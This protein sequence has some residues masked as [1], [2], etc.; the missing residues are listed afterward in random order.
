MIFCNTQ[1]AWR[2][3]SPT[4]P[5]ISSSPSQSGVAARRTPL[6]RREPTSYYLLSSS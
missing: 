6:E 3:G 4:R 1:L 2:L 5:Y